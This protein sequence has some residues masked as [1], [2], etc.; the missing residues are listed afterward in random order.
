MRP[1]LP[2]ALLLILV[3]LQYRLWV[4]DGGLAQTQHLRQ[5]L[6]RN[7]AE[8]QQ[9]RN[10]NAALDAEVHSLK[11]G[12]LCRSDRMAKYNRLLRIER[13]L[14]ARAHYPGAAAFPVRL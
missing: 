8:V 9:L 7:R 5:E 10:R 11:T 6:A 14:G 4:G 12:S 13:E 1:W 3:G 2:V